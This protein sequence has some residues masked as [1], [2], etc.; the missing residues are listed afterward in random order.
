MKQEPASLASWPDRLT[1][2]MQHPGRGKAAID[3]MGVLP[4][5]R[6]CNPRWA[7]PLLAL[8]S[9][10]HGLA[11]CTIEA[12]VSEDLKQ[13]C[14]LKRIVL[15][16]RGASVSPD[17]CSRISE[18]LPSRESPRAGQTE[19]SA[20]AHLQQHESAVLRFMTDPDVPETLCRIPHFVAFEVNAEKART[21]FT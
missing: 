16:H 2:Y 12:F 17:Y 6:D 3:A 8:R 5:Q 9:V 18:F 7:S 10:T 20:L 11:M 4:K 21:R 19:Q 1:Y 14:R 13:N 15:M